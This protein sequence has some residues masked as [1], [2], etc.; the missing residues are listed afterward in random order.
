M[1]LNN[2]ATKDEI[3]ETL[4]QTAPHAGFPAC[5]EGLVMADEVFKKVDAAKK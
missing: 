4:L 2:G 1:A 3:L 5:W